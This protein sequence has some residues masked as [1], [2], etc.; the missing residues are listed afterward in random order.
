MLDIRF[1]QVKVALKSTTVVPIRN[2]F[3]PSIVIQ[4][5]SLNKATE[6]LYNDL[7]VDEY[8][9]QSSTRIIAKIPP[10]QLGKPLTSLQIFAAIEK[11]ANGF[12]IDRRFVFPLKMVSGIDRLI[13]SWLLIFLTT[14]GSDAFSPGGGG[15]RN[16]IGRS[17]NKTAPADLTLA[18]QRTRD[19]LL[20]LQAQVSNLPLSEKLLSS[21]LSSISFDPNTTTVS[22]VVTLQNMLGES[23]NLSIGK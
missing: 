4:G 1:A 5:E 12:L 14:P 15:A 18:V 11:S 10:S 3:P 21:S 6:I 16:L 22:A 23:A 20:R 19:E 17:N 13:Q 9:V 2:F 7:P 8:I